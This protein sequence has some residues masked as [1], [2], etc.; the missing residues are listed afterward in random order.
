MR[1]GSLNPG[2]YRYVRRRFRVLAWVIDLFGVFIASRTRRRRG[3]AAHD[4]QR[5]LIVQLDHLGDALLTAAIIP[6]IRK[7]F[8]RSRIDVLAAPWNQEVFQAVDGIHTIH[9]S[10][11][12]RFSSRRNWLWPLSMIFWGLRLRKQSYDLA[13]DFRGEL[14]HLVLMWLSGARARLGW[15]CAGGGFLLTHQGKY[16]PGRH[17][18]RSRL[19]LINVFRNAPHDSQDVP[20]AWLSPPQDI[21]ESVAQKIDHELHLVRAGQPLLVFH[22]GG[23]ARAKQWPIEHWRELIGRAI[24]DLDARIV[25][26]GGTGDVH[27]CDEILERA[28]W[29]QVTNWAGRLSLMETAALLTV[30]DV[31][32]G[33]DSGPAHLASAVGAQAVVLFS[34]TNRWRQWHPWG[35]R[36][37]ILRSA[38]SCSPCHRTECG[39]A[40]HPC[41]RQIL[42]AAVIAQIVKSLDKPVQLVRSSARVESLLRED[43][44]LSVEGPTR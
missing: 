30:A 11:C 23:R 12:N 31:F 32:V 43:L 14:P 41:L 38:V 4:I 13:I 33:G 16:R 1:R 42:P 40:G 6:R 8:A 35:N 20:G 17:E 15:D 21:R 27:L 26:I 18:I 5:I 24:V 37:R 39:V 22:V 19:H 10:K 25:I 44:E 29:P 36:V 28:P 9:V 2:G 3:P 7:Q 34:G